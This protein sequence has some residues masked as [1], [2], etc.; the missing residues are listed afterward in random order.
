M[1]EMVNNIKLNKFN[2]PVIKEEK[3]IESDLDEINMN[4]IY[5]EE[6]NKI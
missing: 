6:L 1:E 5:M 3:S 4:E 2:L